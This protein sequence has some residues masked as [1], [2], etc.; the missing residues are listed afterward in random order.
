VLSPE[1]LAQARRSVFL[2]AS[3]YDALCSWVNRRYREKLAAVD[4]TD[5]R[6]VEESR[7]ALDELTQILQLGSI[8]A[9]QKMATGPPG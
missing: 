2:T 6:Q 5:P 4:L 3:L 8:Y 7:R 1:Q 9:F